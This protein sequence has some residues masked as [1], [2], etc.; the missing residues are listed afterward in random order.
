MIESAD[1]VLQRLQNDQAFMSHVGSYDFGGGITKDA[2]VVLSSN[3]QV[4]GVKSHT[5]VECVISR[6]PDTKSRAVIAGCSVRLKQWTVYLIQY[7]NA[8]PNQAIDAADRLL[9]LAPGAT[10]TSLGSGFS[11]MAGVEQ[12]V[13]KIPAGVPLVAPA[14]L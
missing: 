14:E 9:D 7:E 8:Q 13:V 11:D 2:I 3:Q 4:P 5:G 1:E 6:V 10:Y 12:I